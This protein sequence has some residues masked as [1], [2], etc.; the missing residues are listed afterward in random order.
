M[1]TRF[2]EKLIYDHTVYVIRVDNATGIADRF[3]QKAQETLAQLEFPNLTSSLDDFKT[4]GWIFNKEVTR[5]LSMTPEKSAFN[6]FGVY[7][8]AQPFGNVVVFSK[9]E[10]IEK[11]FLDEVLSMD[12][13]KRRQR[14]SENCKNLAQKEELWALTRLGDYMYWDALAVVDPTIDKEKIRD[15]LSPF[16]A[17]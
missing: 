3:F 5:M 2:D 13:N 1:A 16:G 17:Q 15:K 7:L 9:Y 4:G 8:R 14:I 11:S 10:I 6:A 12:A